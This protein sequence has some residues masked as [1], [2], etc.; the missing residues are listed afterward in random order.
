MSRRSLLGYSGTAAA[1]AVL[2]TAGSAQAGEVEAAGAPTVEFPLGTQFSGS[3]RI[4][5]ADSG[6]YMAITFTFEPDGTI[7]AEN[8]ITA[9]EVANALS[10]FAVSRGWPPITFSG[11]PAPV[12]I[13]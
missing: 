8:A 13:N 5:D 9:T 6:G 11:R 10:E 12:A 2:G 4:G 1:G 3:S 7:P